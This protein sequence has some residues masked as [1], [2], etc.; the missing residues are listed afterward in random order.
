[1]RPALQLIK[2]RP[3]NNIVSSC[4][5]LVRPA[6]IGDNEVFAMGDC[7]INI[8]PSEDELVEIAL[9]TAECAKI[10]GV[11]PKVAFLRLF[12]LWLR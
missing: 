11:D 8:R 12:H 2:T 10:F 1:M 3:G 9:E 6:A 5:I 4:F 7:A